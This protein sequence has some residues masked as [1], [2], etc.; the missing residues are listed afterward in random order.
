MFKKIFLVLLSLAFSDQ[1]ILAQ[2]TTATIS[3]TL[4]DETGAILP[5]ATVKITNLDTGITRTVITDDQG[6]YH[7]P[8]LSLGNYE[9]Q[10]ELTGFQTG[11]RRGI[12]LTVGREA[13][14]DF[15]LKV[16]EI[17]ERVIVTGEAPLVETTKSEISGLVT[18]E[19]VS[20]LPLNARDFSQLVTLQAGAVQFRHTSG[21]VQAGFGTRIAVSGARTNM[22]AF[23][24][25]GVNI[26]TVAGQLP[27]GVGQAT[28]GV[29]SM[30]EFKVLTSSYSA[31]YGRAAGANI[32]AI[33]KSGTN[34]FH[35]SVFEYIRNDNLDARNFFDREKPEFKRNQFGFSLGGPIVRN[36]TFFFGSYE[37]LRERLGLTEIGQVP[38]P[39]ARQ[40]VL[41]DRRVSVSPLIKPYLDLYPLPNGRDLG[42]GTAEFVNAL[43]RPTDQDYLTIRMDH[44]FSDQHSIF[45]RFTLDNSKRLDPEV[46]DLFAQGLS[47]R[48]RY[49]TLQFQ[50]IFSPKWIGI[51]RFGLN[52]DVSN[53]VHLALV[54]LDPSLSFIEGR[55]FGNLTVR[56]LSPLVGLSGGITPYDSALTLPQYHY[57]V[58]YSGGRH[59]I[60]AGLTAERLILHRKQ[61]QL[62][63][64]SVQF[65]SL[66]DF[67][68][69]A[70]PTRFRMK[71][72]DRLADPFRSF[73]QTLVSFYIQDDIRLHPRLTLNAGVRHEYS[74]S[75]IE[76]YGRLANIR[77]LLDPA[78]TVGEPY[79]K[80]PQA[81][82]F[83]PR[84]GLAWDPTGSGNTSIR[85]GFGIFFEPL[86][87]KQYLITMV[88]QPPF[89][90]AP[91][92]PADQLAGLFPRVTRAKL[93]ELAKGPE[94]V[95]AFDF[96]PDSP[97]MIHYSLSIQ[98]MLAS[99]LVV[100]IT[101]T[102]TRGVHLVSRADFNV[103]VPQ[104]LPDGRIF[105]P[106]A[107]G[108]INPNFGRYHRYGTGADSYYQ[109]LQLMVNKRYNRGFQFQTSYTL[110]K[111][112][113]TQ[114]G[115]FSTE[116]R[117]T[118]VMNP[119]DFKQDKGLADTHVAHN[120][121]GNF[122]YDLPF[123]SNLHGPVAQLVRG[124]QLSGILSLA[125][126][127][128][129]SP[130]ADPRVVHPLLRENNVRPNL[131]AGANNNPVLGGPDK[132]FD[133]SVFELPQ[134]GFFGNLGRNTLIGPGVAMLDFSLIKN[135]FVRG[136][137]R[138][139]QFR[140]EFFNLFNRANFGSP[141]SLVFDS[142][143]RRLGGAGRITN[144][145]TTAR[146]IQFALRF[147]F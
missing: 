93:E 81:A 63:G 92:P 44:Q 121:V 33:T 7:A 68:T 74:T 66:V 83:G 17:T 71:G 101:Y 131:Q 76:K 57:E 51:F 102:G 117:G 46:L 19:Q 128:P 67:L 85:A 37:G 133:S 4:K 124:W 40:G 47:T 23:S 56:G 97:Y 112:I 111:N 84:L 125:T 108:Y 11:V 147:E 141:A 105:F 50:S 134:P 70:P 72:P 129:L 87:A 12:T 20:L 10:A 64:G 36:K 14:V 142:R 13:I 118:T 69:N 86:T 26:N 34:E 115:H 53:H 5:G 3:G 136:E 110:S 58:N 82:N 1:I 52:R 104:F 25:D 126:G 132:Y 144:T 32:V 109:G 38:T 2:V 60:K 35:G 139:L 6:R 80:N 114:S 103:P 138:R 41:P 127:N 21:N 119:F 116:V 122:I 49:F 8:N 42:D 106:R 137:N 107:A 22:N 73:F 130:G 89:W 75:P 96:E 135:F 143:G 39:A 98:R 120:F 43:K 88:L 140:S 94:S 28:L 62:E 24:L 95:H 99:D 79:F 146:Q 61:D 18:R 30:R 100:A 65:G 9:V 91:D 29:E 15:T 59:A 27:A 55:S 31:E 77:H 123:G 78:A 48:N 145:T 16:G 90:S 113:D 54:K 45:G